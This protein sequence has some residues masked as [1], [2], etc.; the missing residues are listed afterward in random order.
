M[1]RPVPLRA[2]ALHV[3]GAVPP[4]A[5]RPVNEK[6]FPT[7]PL[8]S[9]PPATE[10]ADARTLLGV[11]VPSVEAAGEPTD[12]GEPLAAFHDP[13]ESPVVETVHPFETPVA[14]EANENVEPLAVC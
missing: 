5:L 13:S 9:A 6:A 3:Y 8:W 12:F 14:A 10:R 4:E 2:G 1:L 11:E 7:V